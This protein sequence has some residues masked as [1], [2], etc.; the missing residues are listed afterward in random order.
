MI[1]N[2]FKGNAAAKYQVGIEW[3]AQGLA[4]V[5]CHGNVCPEKAKEGRRPTVD[6]LKILLNED[7]NSLSLLTDWV[8]ESGLENAA[9]NLVLDSSDYQLLLVEAPDVPE[10]EIRDAVR[11]R[12]KD[13]ISIPVDKAAIDL[14]M[15]PADG[16]RGGKKMAYVV[17]AELSR[18]V[19]RVDQIKEAGLTLISIDIAELALRNVAYLKELDQPEGRGVAIVR[20]VEGGGTVSLYRKG[21]LYLSRH[22]SLSYSGG[23]LDDIPID[24]FI[25]EVQRSLD[26]Y[27]RQMAQPPPSVLFVCG[28]NITED[29]ITKDIA[30]GMSVP[31]RYLDLTPVADPE[32]LPDDTLMQACVVA[33]GG[34]LRS[35]VS[36]C[37]EMEVEG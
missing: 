18:I 12:I 16:S 20:L 19:E 28:E 3:Q 25:L 36:D 13:L 26:Y 21:N 6:R 24:S 22:F 17:V 33:I 10:E 32:N 11:W 1:R 5:S 23:L 30:Y 37:S 27:E 7:N 31:V 2:L 9:C 35:A 29:K 14:F 15:L 34:A 4:V 8:T